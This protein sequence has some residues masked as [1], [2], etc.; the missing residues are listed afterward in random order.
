MRL[1]YNYFKWPLKVHTIIAGALWLFIGIVAFFYSIPGQHLVAWTDHTWQ[2]AAQKTGRHLKQVEVNWLTPSHYTKTEEILKIIQVKQGDAMA[3]VDLNKIQ[4]KIEKLPWV[5]TAI[6]E[7][8]WPNALKITIEEK[9]PLALW[10]NNRR[11]HPLDDQAQIIDTT[12]QLPADLL[13]VVGPDAPKHLIALIKNLEQVPE[14]YQY[15]RAAVRVGER[16]WNLK[17]FD[18]EKG[19][20]VLL[21]ETNILTALKRLDDHNK[22]EKLIK[23]KVAA[24]DLRTKDK[25]ILKPLASEPEKPKQ[26]ASKK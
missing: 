13:L 26:K 22:K 5:R 17:L 21:P 24:I 10:Q 23:R 3:N 12:R 14:I 25:V 4:E 1:N 20:E 16:R 9:L 8:Y 15:V 11:Y 2:L 7:R 18:A 19:L 6:V